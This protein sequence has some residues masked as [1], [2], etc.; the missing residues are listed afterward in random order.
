ML[1]KRVT[2]ICGSLQSM[3]ANQAML[4]VVSSSFAH[5]GGY[6]VVSATGLGDIPALNPERQAVIPAEVSNLRTLL[7]SSDAVVIASPEYAGGIAGGL[8]N[9]LDW[10]VGS[11]EF[12]QKPVALMS[13]GTS[14]G[15]IALSQ[16]A[17]TLT[18][19]GAYVVSLLG[20]M[21]PKSKS[22]DNGVIV[23]EESI[24][25]IKSVAALLDNVLSMDRSEVVHIAR[26][27]A[28]QVGYDPN[29]II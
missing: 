1:V 28:E 14:G 10:I 9:C 17:R 2:T 20:M 13:A 24:S 16:M 5:T 15:P 6:E 21:G 19:H 3:S 29:R 18:W 26:E 11:G 8:K 27:I 23:D 12:Y 22:D 25:Q 4:D 7:G